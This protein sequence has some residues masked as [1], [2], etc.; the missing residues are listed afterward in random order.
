[1]TSSRSPLLERVVSGESRELLQL[2]ARGLL[3]VAPEELIPLQVRL[4]Q[5]EDR[6]LA[7]EAAGALKI[8][9]VRVAAHFL[10]RGAGPDELAYFARASSDAVALTAVLR[11]RDVPRALLGDLARRLPADLQE[12]L[13]LR[14]DAIVEEPSI[15]DALEE[16]P[17]LSTYARRRIGEYREHLLPRQ[18]A[19]EEEAAPF[20]RGEVEEADDRTVQ[21]A[22]LD[23]R[24]QTADGELED[25]TGLS[26]GQIRLLPVPVRLRLARGAHRILRN[27]LIRD[28]HPQVAVA[29]LKINPVSD[30]EVEQIAA[31]RLVVTEVFEEIVRR[32]QWIA[33]YPILRTLV[34]NPR[35]PV[36]IALRLVPRLAVRDLRAL[37]RERN[38]ADPVRALAQRLYVVKRM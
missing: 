35:V 14:Q 9:D 30:Q 16:N 34:F 4:A 7:R 15:L 33:K 31:N 5:G 32:R 22:I 24:S 29:V 19:L 8:L 6:D 21:E 20:A 11:R 27:M 36:A 1:M 17:E 2:A 28:P 10:E 38:V 12:L 23:V 13:L 26:E 37:S 25:V 3:P 18:R